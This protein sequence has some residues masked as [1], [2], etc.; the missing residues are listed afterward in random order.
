[1]DKLA[2]VIG[3]G[4]YSDRNKLPNIMNAIVCVSKW[5]I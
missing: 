5:S 3:N 2:L 4:K 1:V